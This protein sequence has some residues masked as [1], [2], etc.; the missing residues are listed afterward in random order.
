[1]N[2]IFKKGD[3]VYHY[4]H[5]KAIITNCYHTLATV[6]READDKYIDLMND[7]LSFTP[8]TLENGGLSHVRPK[9]PEFEIG[10]FVK[11]DIGQIVVVTKASIPESHNFEGVLIS[12]GESRCFT[13]GRHT[14][15]WNKS[16]FTKTDIAIF[17]KHEKQ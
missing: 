3:T 12:Q 1:M 15:N 4:R 11:S 13:V 2:E 14:H 17:Y 7:E 9:K 6:Q 16:S 10:D 8:Y 5:G